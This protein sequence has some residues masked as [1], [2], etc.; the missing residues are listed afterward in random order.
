[1]KQRAVYPRFIVLSRAAATPR[2]ERR[3]PAGCGSGQQPVEPSRCRGGCFPPEPALTQRRSDGQRGGGTS[4]PDVRSHTRVN[5]PGSRIHRNL[6]FYDFYTHTHTHTE[7]PFVTSPRQRGLKPFRLRR[8]RL[9]G[10][11]EVI[12]C[13]GRR[14]PAPR[15][16]GHLLQRHSYLLTFGPGVKADL[17]PSRLLPALTPRCSG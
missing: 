13:A 8:C 2:A 1:M 16:L 12:C 7:G 9:G 11:D 14:Y 15:D 5:K 4:R 10:R 17:F 3:A 6:T